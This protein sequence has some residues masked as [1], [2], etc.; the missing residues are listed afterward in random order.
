MKRG[1][2]QQAGRKRGPGSLA[3]LGYSLQKCS[4]W[5]T[6]GL[7]QPEEFDHNPVDR[8][9]PQKHRDMPRTH[10]SKKLESLKPF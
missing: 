3:L 9:K 6:T 1:E 7:L 8:E 4:P 2:G 10:W 5:V